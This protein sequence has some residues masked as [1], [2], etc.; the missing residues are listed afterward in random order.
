MFA[1][2]AALTK[3]VLAL[4]SETERWTGS[5][6]KQNT[7]FLKVCES[8]E[9]Y[10]KLT[11]KINLKTVYKMLGVQDNPSANIEVTFLMSKGGI[12]ASLLDL[13]L[14]MP[15]NEHLKQA[16]ICR[17]NGMTFFAPIIASC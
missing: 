11:A 10:A 16:V 8:N 12:Y 17:E 4:C 1:H 5:R 6:R 2:V 9:H 3:S 14:A 7:E 13:L 15:S